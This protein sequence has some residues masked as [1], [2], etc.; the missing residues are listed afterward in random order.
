MSNDQFLLVVYSLFYLSVYLS[1]GFRHV[2]LE[3]D[4]QASIFVHVTMS[5]YSYEQV[6]NILWWN[7]PDYS[8]LGRPNLS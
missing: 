5:D 6:I 2:H 3:G 4:Q 7:E 8:Y 1:K